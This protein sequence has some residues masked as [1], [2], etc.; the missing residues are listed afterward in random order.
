MLLCVACAL[1]APAGGHRPRLPTPPGVRPSPLYKPKGNEVG[2]SHHISRL[3]PEHPLVV[4]T[5]FSF[6][7][8]MGKGLYAERRLPRFLQDA[9][10]AQP[11]ATMLTFGSIGLLALSCMEDE[12]ATPRAT[13]GGLRAA[14]AVTPAD[15]AAG[16]LKCKGENTWV[17]LR[18]Y[19][20]RVAK[21][22]TGAFTR[23]CT[24]HRRTAARAQW[25]AAGGASKWRRRRRRR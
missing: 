11:S 15:V 6:A 14:V 13:G 16:L 12:P 19:A 24:C 17:Y 18:T 25:V 22:R 20:P 3:L 2:L 1:A 4:R 21:V 7:F 23:W 9:L 5:K 10:D 8:G